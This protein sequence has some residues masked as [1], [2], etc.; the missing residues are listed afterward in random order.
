MLS[1]RPSTYFFSKFVFNPL[2][3]QK[4]K[5][6]EFEVDQRFEY[7]AP[8]FVDFQLLQEG[9]LEDNDMDKWFGK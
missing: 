2:P 6:A 1:D 7:D 3:F 5:M 8:T 9:Q 4:E